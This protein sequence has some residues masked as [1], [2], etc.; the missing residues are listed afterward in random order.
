MIIFLLGM[1]LHAIGQQKPEA[2]QGKVAPA[3]TYVGSDACKGCHKDVATAWATNAHSKTLAAEGLT[4]GLKGCES[5]HGPASAH[6]ADPATV[7]PVNPQ[8]ISKDEASKV[9]GKCHFEGEPGAVKD[10]TIQQK[11]WRRSEHNR[12][13]VSCM[14]CHSVHA[15][16]PKLLKKQSP[17]LCATCHQDI[18]K[19]GDYQHAPVASGACLN[20]HDPH[21]SNSRHH[22]MADL[23]KLCATCHNPKAEKF[24]TAHHGYDLTGSNCTECHSAHSRDKA[25]KLVKA[26]KHTPF[27]SGQCQTCHKAD[28]LELAK[29]EKELC[30]MCHS[31]DLAEKPASD[32]HMH[33]PVAEGM[34]TRCHSPH[35]SDAPN[36]LWKDKTVAYSCFLCHNKVENSAYATYPHKPMSSL[37]CQSCHSPHTSKQNNMLAKDSIE[38]CKGCHK[39]TA[40]PFGKMPDGKV[41]IDPTTNDMLTCASC[42]DA[43][44][45]EFDKLTR[46]DKNAA[47]CNRCHKVS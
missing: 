10:K 14:A 21:G 26:Q 33:A 39:P 15:A 27:K 24:A 7:K 2:E 8:K 40:H 35:A 3:A 34:C 11:Y 42:H 20:C 36:G 41:V 38:L 29:P 17:E 6:I 44:G 9:C 43:H 45:S 25:G 46:E 19:K 31:K 32:V 4:D 12:G 22:L 5:C 30:T 16:S 37:N 28:S 13:D 47:L 1:G 18:V 23:P